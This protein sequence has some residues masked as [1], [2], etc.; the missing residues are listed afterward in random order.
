MK[1]FIIILGLLF[2]VASPVFAYSISYTGMTGYILA[3]TALTTSPNSIELTTS[4]V[5]QENILFIGGTFSFIDNWEIGISKDFLMEAESNYNSPLLVST[6][7]LFYEGKVDIAFGALFG[8]P[9]LNEYNETTTFEPIIMFHSGS[10]FGKGM[11]DITI[12]KTFYFSPNGSEQS[13]EINLYIGT[14]IPV[15]SNSFFIL[16]DFSNNSPIDKT[17]FDDG[18]GIF[19]FGMLLELN[20]NL[21]FDIVFFDILDGFDSLVGGFTANLKLYF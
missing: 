2:L 11:M 12:G 8:F 20:K 21:S 5:F 6:K 10:I 17:Y 13:Q 19:N 3:P 18:R 9:I 14:K 7:Y 1:K 15:F 4:F 16:A